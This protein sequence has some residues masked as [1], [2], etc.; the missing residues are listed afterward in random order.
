MINEDDLIGLPDEL[1]K[2][3][4]ITQTK[5]LNLLIYG[6][7]KESGGASVDEILLFVYRKTGEV[8][9]RTELVSRMYRMKN[10]GQVEIPNNRK[11][12]YLA[13]EKIGGQ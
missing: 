10:R 13:V 1:L 6:F 5:R 2:E 9:K 11:G 7:I 12:F 8:M 3:L 4:N